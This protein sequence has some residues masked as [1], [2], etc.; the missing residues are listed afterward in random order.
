MDVSRASFKLEPLETE[1]YIQ[2]PREIEKGNVLR[3]YWNL[4][5]VWMKQVE[6]ESKW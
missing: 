4:S 3:K 1:T 6:K 2:L 5:L